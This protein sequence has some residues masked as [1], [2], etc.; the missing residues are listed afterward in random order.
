M[1][2]VAVVG[3]R[4]P[5]WAALGDGMQLL[6]VWVAH[7]AEVRRFVE[8]LP[9]GTFF[10]SGGARGV[11]SAAEDAARRRGFE[12]AIYYPWEH[13][14]PRGRNEAL[15]SSLCK[16]DEL[17]AFPWPGCHGT[18]HVFGLAK[19]RPGVRCVVHYAKGLPKGGHGGVR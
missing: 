10:V 14:G 6:D 4:P 9:D 13:G 1:A 5:D 16:G 12:R 11:D 18:W 19:K 2:R 8:S 3:A 17:H 15:A 7:L